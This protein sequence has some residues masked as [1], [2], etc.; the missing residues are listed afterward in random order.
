MLIQISDDFDLQKIAESGQCFRW[1]KV[2]LYSYR[3]IAGE[4]CLYIT[5][6]EENVF[7]LNEN[8]QSI[9]ARIERE[10]DPF[11]WQAADQEKG[12][13]ILRQDPWEMLTSF[14]ISQNKNIPAISR[15]IETLASRCGEKKIDS[16]GMEYDGFPKPEAIAALSEK[17]LLECGLGYRWK[18]V[19]AAAKAV[20][21]GDIDLNKLVTSDEETAMKA[22]TS[23]Y[24]VGLKVANCVS[25]FG[26]HYTNA[27]PVDVW[28]KRIL[29]DQ[30]PGGYPFERYSPYNGIFQQY[31]F[32]YYR[33]KERCK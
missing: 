15:C 13:R 17:D 1:T 18:Y 8:Y 10:K 29:A 3:I 30:Y 19:H 26:L 33:H 31:M 28:V 23:L 20:L 5:A 12:I 7:D 16:K 24:G 14:I 25:L 32:T 11:L 21:S 22:L 27:F 4:K 2:D 9:R 6:H